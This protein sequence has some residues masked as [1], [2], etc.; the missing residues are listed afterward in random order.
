MGT[1]FQMNSSILCRNIRGVASEEKARALR[2]SVMKFKPMLV[3]LQGTK[4]EQLSE[5]LINFMW[6]NHNRKWCDLPSREAAGGIV[7]I[8]DSDKLEVLDSHS[9]IF[10]LSLLCKSIGVAENWVFTAVYGLV[11]QSEKERFWEELDDVGHAWTCPWILAGDFNAVIKRSEGSTGRASRFERQKFQ[12]FIDEH[13]LLEFNRAGPNFTF[14]NGHELP[15][16]SR[17]DRFLANPLWFEIFHDHT[18]IAKGYHN[19]D[20]RLLVL[21]D[22][23]RAVGPKPFRFELYWLNDAELLDLLKS[24]WES[25]EVAGKPG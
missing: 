12:D 10:T 25:A 23:G 3:T 17:L 2:R 6:G 21:E 15:T 4:Q 16:L 8:W 20:H 19:S 14:S 22:S 7:I 18:E 11:L 24:W 9:G 5:R 1:Q 13:G